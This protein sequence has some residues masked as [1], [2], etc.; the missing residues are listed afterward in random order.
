MTSSIPALPAG[1]RSQ[2]FDL[3]HGIRLS[4]RVAGAADAPRLVFLH[5]FPQAAFIWDELLLH[6][7][8]RFLCIAPNLRG[9]E[10]S[11]A[12]AAVEAYR[13]KHLVADIAALI[14]ASGPGPLAALVAH[15][16]GGALAWNLAVARPALLRRLVM[17][18]SP[19]PG[20][21]LR[22]LQHNPLQQAASAYMNF[23]ARPDAAALLAEDDFG[24]MW[25]FFLNMGGAR[26]LTPAL[27]ETY[28]ALWRGD[29]SAEPGR[30]LVGPS[31]YYAASPLRPPTAEDA[32]A[33]RI[34][35]ADEQ[36]TVRVPT[37][38]VWGEADIALPTAL[39][40]GLER[41]VPDLDVQR[42]PG[43][44]HWLLQEDAAP[45]IEGLERALARAV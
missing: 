38:V 35:L 20:A 39:L 9:Y 7:A 13:P 44:S 10:H 15:D 37:T 28:R 34:Q 12:P 1:I 22:E 43:A 45:V 25:P 14:G 4:C 21:F 32:G 24:R 30:G 2:C 3:P 6:L 29:G 17:I 33:A 36:L 31:N 42:V 27:R 26:W 40:D 23:L 11:S 16:W 18:N 41:W 19:H 8:P 5:G